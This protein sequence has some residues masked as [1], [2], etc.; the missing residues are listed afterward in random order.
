[1]AYVSTKKLIST[2]RALIM[3]KNI[4]SVLV[5]LVVLLAIVLFSSYNKYYGTRGGM[6]QGV[7]ISDVNPASHQEFVKWLEGQGF[8][9]VDSPITG[10][11]SPGVH[12]RKETEVWYEG[13]YR[14]SKN[15]NVT[16]RM[17]EDENSQDL[18]ALVLYDLSGWKWDTEKDIKKIK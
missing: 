18:Y 5:I 6:M 14:G 16:I 17:H 7:W 13:T 9:E 2:A 1:M 10:R 11:I 12:T 3:K 8:S 4:V 15:F